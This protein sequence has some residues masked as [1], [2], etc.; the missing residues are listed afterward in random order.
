MNA[1]VRSA[2]EIPPSASAL[3]INRGDGVD[4]ARRRGSS[5]PLLNR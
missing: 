5:F 2:A 4:K 3:T 1:H